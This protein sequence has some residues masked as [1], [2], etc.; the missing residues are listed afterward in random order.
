MGHAR[1]VERDGG[2]RRSVR[3]REGA[4]LTLLIDHEQGTQAVLAD[5]CLE[6]RPRRA[7]WP[8]SGHQAARGRPFQLETIVQGAW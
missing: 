6:Q 5:R 4:F 8:M 3:L 1:F 2:S 7:A